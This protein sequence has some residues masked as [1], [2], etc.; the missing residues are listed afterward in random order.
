MSD[1][2]YSRIQATFA[3]GD[4]RENPNL[5]IAYVL[6]YDHETDEVISSETVDISS[7]SG[8]FQFTGLLSSKKYRISVGS[9]IDNDNY[10]GQWGEFFDSVPA[11]ND[12][13]REFFSI[14]QN[15]EDVDINLVPISGIAFGAL[16][17]NSNIKFDKPNKK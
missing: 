6:L 9:D 8:S 1:G 13:D 12:P 10:I 11:F 4:P 7:G 16:K 3:V 5:G 2:T 14:D 15:V 17:A